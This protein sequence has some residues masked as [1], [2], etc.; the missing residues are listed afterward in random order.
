MS[1][2]LSDLFSTKLVIDERLNI[3]GAQP[4]DF[5][6]GLAASLT[7]YQRIS[8]ISA[9]GNN[10][11][12]WQIY[13][14]S[15][16]SVLAPVFIVSVPITIQMTGTG[17]NGGL[18]VQEGRDAPRALEA[19]ISTL[20]IRLNNC[21]ID[22]QPNIVYDVNALYQ[23]QDS[24]MSSM[25][26]ASFPDNC[27]AYKD[28]STG[29]SNPLASYTSSSRY[30]PSRGAFPFSI[31]N[32]TNTTATVTF[33][34]TSYINMAPFSNSLCPTKGLS[35]LTSLQIDMQFSPQLARVWSHAIGGPAGIQGTITGAVVTVGGNAG[36]PYLSYLEMTPA[37]SR[38]N[39]LPS[40]ILVYNTPDYKIQQQ[41][42]ITTLAAGGR[43]AITTT[44]YQLST[45][46][47][48]M[49]IFLRE[50]QTQLQTAQQQMSVPNCY[51]AIESLTVQNYNNSSSLFSSASQELMYVTCAQNGLRSTFSEYLG[52]TYI[53]NAAGN[54]TTQIGLTGS[55]IKLSFGKDIQQANSGCVPGVSQSSNISFG[56]TVVNRSDRAI[57]YDLFVVYVNSAL[58]LIDSSSGQK[59]V[60]ILTPYESEQSEIVQ[61]THDTEGG[62]I[63]WQSVRNG[64]KK[65]Y[66]YA[67][68]MLGKMADDATPYA[69]KYMGD[70]AANALRARLKEK[71]G[72]GA[73][74]NSHARV[75]GG[76]RAAGA[77]GGATLSKK[78]LSERYT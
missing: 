60:S 72:F 27:Q 64:L 45:V 41:G 25:V 47:D 52:F 8:S 51:A 46:P 59:Y 35:N 12:Q 22:M 48:H 62:K 26:Y 34:A 38:V 4:V 23:Q 2:K 44:N 13:P 19:I 29:V 53:P 9:G 37:V 36:T 58:L 71:A 5:S 30:T 77:S 70:D 16:A 54:G 28:M 17:Y 15:V 10:N 74:G 3:Y 20:S 78:S 14:S 40:S 69:A 65:A 6:T 67:K 7:N 55:V 73:G 31:A 33:V 61:T 11:V 43:A 50:S 56:L 21:P 32:N 57:T 68:P 42:A 1:N 49:L 18:L 63:N 24:T 39:T 75:T 76:A 66:E